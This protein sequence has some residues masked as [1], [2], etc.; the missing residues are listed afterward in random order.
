MPGGWNHIITHM[1]LLNTHA[2]YNSEAITMVSGV[3]TDSTCCSA[4]FLV[5]SRGGLVKT[6]M[7]TSGALD[8]PFRHC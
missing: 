2:N 3:P 6:N 1:Q 5:A 4:G 8:V 7:Q